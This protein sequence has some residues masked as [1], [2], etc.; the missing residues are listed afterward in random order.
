MSLDNRTRFAAHALRLHAE[1]QST[2]ALDTGHDPITPAG[3]RSAEPDTDSANGPKE[4]SDAERAPWILEPSGGSDFTIRNRTATP[5]Y[6]VRKEGGIVW[7]PD[8]GMVDGYAAVEVD[9]LRGV[10]GIDHNIVIT[11]HLRGD[12]SDARLSWK[13]EVPR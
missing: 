10:G 6:G 7:Q 5:K 11:W 2:S 1:S 8:V 3:D 12:S 9:A 4:T 13:G